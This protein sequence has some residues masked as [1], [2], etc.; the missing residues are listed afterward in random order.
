MRSKKIIL[1]VTFIMLGN[2]LASR[3]VINFFHNHDHEISLCHFLCDGKDIVK[4]NNGNCKVCELD[5]FHD[6]FCYQLTYIFL[7]NTQ[8]TF[9]SNSVVFSNAASSYLPEGRAPPLNLTL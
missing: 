3:V 4:E 9:V 6:L 8:F 2:L 5:I 1:I 7:E